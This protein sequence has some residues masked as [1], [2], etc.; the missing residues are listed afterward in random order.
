M[1]PEARCWGVP[2]LTFRFTAAFPD[3]DRF[4]I[5]LGAARATAATKGAR[6]RNIMPRLIAGILST[7]IDQT[8]D[9][10]K[11]NAA[12]L[13]DFIHFEYY[14]CRHC[15]TGRSYEALNS[16]YFLIAVNWTSGDRL[17]TP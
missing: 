14:T 7:L 3:T 16:H 5:A 13:I 15:P 11:A 1:K 4:S 8:I 2:V 12:V 10:L 17:M 9:R 6:D